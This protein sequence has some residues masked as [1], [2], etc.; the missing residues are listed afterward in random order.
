MRDV[1]EPRPNSQSAK[2]I[3]IMNEPKMEKG[4]G[5]QSPTTVGD[6]PLLWKPVGG[7]IRFFRHMNETAYPL[8]KQ[9]QQQLKKTR[10]KIQKNILIIK[11]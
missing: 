10:I 3:A 9:T 4:I 8:C 11:K 5:N 1:V 2:W 6:P 7:D